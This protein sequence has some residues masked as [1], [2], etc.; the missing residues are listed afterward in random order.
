MGMST[1]IRTMV[2]AVST[3]EW[4]QFESYKLN[5]FAANKI[6]KNRFKILNTCILRKSNALHK[7]TLNSEND[8]L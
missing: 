8:Q 4:K 7:K 5:G 2:K 3:L 6:L 1:W